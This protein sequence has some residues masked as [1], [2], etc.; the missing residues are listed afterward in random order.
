MKVR[1]CVGALLV[2]VLCGCQ[3][4]ERDGEMYLY[5]SFMLRP[6]QRT[7]AKKPETKTT[8]K[9]VQVAVDGGN[10]ERLLHLDRQLLSLELERV[11]CRAECVSRLLKVNGGQQ[12]LIREKVRLHQAEGAR[13]TAECRRLE[14][15]IE[16]SDPEMK[17]LLQGRVLHLKQ[18]AAQHLALA[19]H[20]IKQLKLLEAEQ[21]RLQTLLQAEKGGPAS[22]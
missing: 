4:V 5:P 2:S 13:L 16:H 20:Q 12:S 8:K 19:D 14:P 3:M 1:I 21:S 15:V 9:P 11:S 7:L 10:E 6:N 18:Q 17:A 22:S